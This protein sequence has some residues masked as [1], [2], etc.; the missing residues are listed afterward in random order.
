MTKITPEQHAE[1]M[2]RRRHCYGIDQK[3][4]FRT[5][6]A[7]KKAGLRVSK[8]MQQPHA[9]NLGGFQIL[10]SNGV[11][12]GFDFDL[13]VKDVVEFCEKYEE[14]QSNEASKRVRAKAQQKGDYS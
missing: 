7:A 1:Y 3:G 11:V 12:A 6:R 9:N 8:S 14:K 5:R 10:D 2:K 13:N 4:Y